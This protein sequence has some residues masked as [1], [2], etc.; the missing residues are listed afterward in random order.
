MQLNVLFERFGPNFWFHFRVYRHDE[1]TCAKVGVSNADYGTLRLGSQFAPSAWI[2]VPVDPLGRT[3]NGSIFSLMQQLPGISGNAR[4]SL[5]VVNNAVQCISPRVK[6]LKAHCHSASKRSSVLMRTALHK[7]EMPRASARAPVG[8]CAAAGIEREI[9]KR[10]RPCRRS[11]LVAG[12]GKGTR[13][14]PVLRIRRQILAPPQTGWL[15]CNST[16][17]ASVSALTRA[18]L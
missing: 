6:Q 3:T 16:T 14:R 7:D 1:R 17:R 12:L 9:E 8:G 13:T 2:T 18:G 10:V 4:G 5:G 11:M 15:R